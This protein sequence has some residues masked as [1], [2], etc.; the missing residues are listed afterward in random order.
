MVFKLQS[1]YVPWADKYWL[2]AEH[3]AGGPAQPP[4]PGAPWHWKPYVPPAACLKENELKFADLRRRFAAKWPVKDGDPKGFLP[5]K[6]R[7][8][9]AAEGGES[10]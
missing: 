5:L 8:E 7:S 10:R 4:P 3:L 6:A 2:G 9:K 1:Q